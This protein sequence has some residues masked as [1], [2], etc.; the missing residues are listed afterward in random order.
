MS[1]KSLRR[2]KV[3]EEKKNIVTPIRVA[4]PASIRAKP[5]SL[6]QLKTDAVAMD[7]D[8]LSQAIIAKDYLVVAEFGA[9]HGAYFVE[10]C[11]NDGES[12]DDASFAPEIW[13][14]QPTGKVEQLIA[15]VG[16]MTNEQV[17]EVEQEM[18][19][20]FGKENIVMSILPVF[21]GSGRDFRPSQDPT[22]RSG[23]AAFVRNNGEPV[24]VATV[25]PQPRKKTA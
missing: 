22:R 19:E 8:K 13:V 24:A 14:I 20:R 5:A 7:M 9:E 23:A 25:I 12:E 17:R 16:A 4:E 18:L 10:G 11:L 21:L 1:V 15:I 3:Y 2:K 6:K